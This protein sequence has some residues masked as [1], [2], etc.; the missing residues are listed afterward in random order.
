MGYIHFSLPKRLVEKIIQ[1]FP[2]ENFVETGTYKGD[3]SF[4]AAAYFKNV[5]T[6]EID[7]D[8]SKSTSERPDCPL[9][10]KFYI[11]NSRNV[12]PKLVDELEGSSLFWL[13]GHWCFDAGGKDAECPLLDEI[14]ALKNLIDPIIFIDDAR[15]FL[16]PLPL[17]H[18]A[19]DWPSIDKIFSLL[20]SLFPNN[21][22][23][24]Q[25]DVIMCVPEEVKK[26]L[27]QDWMENYHSRYPSPI[28]EIKKSKIT[29]INNY[30]KKMAR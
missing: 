11:G 18:K 6:I 1:L 10:I 22:T 23:T 3:S 7:S 16:G 17:P 15:C 27:D 13:D 29:R 28:V 4:W 12:L 24:I 8:I 5:Y 9:N 14:Q 30:L 25:D 21:Y 26:I 20:K 19:E 2:I